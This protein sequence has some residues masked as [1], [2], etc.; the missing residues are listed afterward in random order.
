MEILK[1]R[2]ANRDFSAISYD[3]EPY[4]LSV[5]VYDVEQKI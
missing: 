4:Y 3:D 2:L 5:T 1:N